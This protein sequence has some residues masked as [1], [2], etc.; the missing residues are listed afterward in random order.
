M[1]SIDA[2]H[3]QS[4]LWCFPF[5]NNCTDL[6]GDREATGTKTLLAKWLSASLVYLLR[7]SGMRLLIS[8]DSDRCLEVK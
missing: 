3:S 2:A 4:E 7:M 1:R 6:L 5:T 8:F